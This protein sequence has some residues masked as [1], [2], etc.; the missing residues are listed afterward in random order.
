MELWTSLNDLKIEEDSKKRQRSNENWVFPV[1]IEAW[2][3]GS[4]AQNGSGS[5]E[6]R[7]PSIVDN[8]C[9]TRMNSN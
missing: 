8:Y 7:F 1:L 4:S 3:N 9:T 6:P 5:L 2:V